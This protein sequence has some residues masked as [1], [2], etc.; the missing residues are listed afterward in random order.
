[1]QSSF[2]SQGTQDTGIYIPCKDR[3][4]TYQVWGVTK[5]GRY[6]VV[7]HTVVS[8]PHLGECRDVRAME[9][10]K[11]EPAYKYVESCPADEFLPSLT[12]VDKFIDSL[13][14]K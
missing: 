6:T 13:Q 9:A 8:N 7:A 2:L 3:F 1:M 12:A 11:S 10:L 14:L 4:L 5:D